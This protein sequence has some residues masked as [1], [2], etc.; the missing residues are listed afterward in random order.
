M[1]KIAQ[2]EFTL[3]FSRS[4]GAGGQS[5]N[6]LNTK[7]T[8][9]WNIESSSCCRDEVKKRFIEKYKH[10]MSGDVVTIRSQRYRSQKRNIDDCV[11][12]LNDFLTSVE[13]APKNRRATKPTKGSV[14]R[15]LEHKKMRS[16]NKKLRSEKF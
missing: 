7:A 1:K 11:N 4:S 2:S 16:I 8:L 3:T 5:V 6:K 15:R 13:Y 14:K 12:K 9:T 10:Y